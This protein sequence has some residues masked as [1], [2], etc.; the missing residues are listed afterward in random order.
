MR[1]RLISAR[2]E[3]PPG[4]TVKMDL[5]LIINVLVGS[6]VQECSPQPK[7]SPTIANKYTSSSI[8]KAITFAFTKPYS[9]S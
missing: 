9:Y 7:Y 3:N 5:L 1:N 2:K 8:I 6:E 4:K